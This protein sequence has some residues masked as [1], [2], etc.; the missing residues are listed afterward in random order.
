MRLPSALTDD[1]LQRLIAD[2]NKRLDLPAHNEAAR[3]LWEAYEQGTPER[4]PL[5]LGINPRFILLDPALNPEKVTFF[6]YTTDPELMLQVQ[7]RFQCWV[8]HA[9]IQ[10]ADMGLPDA[11]GVYPDLQNYYEGIW[12]GCELFFHENEVPD[13]RPWLHDDNKRQLFECGIP[14][15]FGEGLARNLEYYR[16]FKRRVEEGFEFLGRPLKDVGLSGLG[17]DG[18]FTTACQLRGAT[19]LCLDLYRD[20]D[21]VREL[22]AFITEA[23][24]ARIKAYR[25]FLAQPL[26][27]QAWGLADDS[28]ELLS[29]ETYKEFVLPHHRRLLETF[30]EGGPHSIHLCG[31]AQR[32]FPVLKQELNIQSF[33]TGFPI[34]FAWVRRTLGPEVWIQGGP[35]VQLLLHGTPEQV[36]EEVKRI[37][38]TG[39]TEGK[40]FM[41]REA[42]NLAP[43]TSLRNLD[44]FYQAAVTYGRYD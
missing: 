33:D 32:H 26:K 7:V 4:V 8:R 36:T 11:W 41:L 14:D 23:T 1:S 17:T 27:T 18:T 43:G 16:Y 29:V 2:S 38:A 35:T 37:T 40:R 5:R 9:I 3:A 19:D 10:D 24:I 13:C 15:P 30:A 44:A 6:E 39:V 31:D 12:L 34:D 25:E 21:Y 20:P 22:L 28:I 42:N